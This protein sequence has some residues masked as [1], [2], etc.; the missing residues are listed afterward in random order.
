[1]QLTRAQQLM[2]I[3]YLYVEEQLQTL[4]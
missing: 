3:G 4:V 1:G 2:G